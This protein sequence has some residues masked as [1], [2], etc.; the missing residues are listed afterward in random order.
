M[1]D[2][3]LRLSKCKFKLF[4][5]IQ[6]IPTWLMFLITTYIATSQTVLPSFIQEIYMQTRIRFFSFRLFGFMYCLLLSYNR[7]SFGI[8]N[9]LVFCLFR[10]VVTI[11]CLTSNEVF[12]QSVCIYRLKSVYLWKSQPPF[13]NNVGWLTFTTRSNCDHHTL[14]TRVL[15]SVFMQLVRLNRWNISA[16]LFCI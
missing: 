15:Y 9:I 16:I 11:K 8:S 1:R 12:R 2:G 14:E 10:N 4:R 5:L 6:C 7:L 3:V 13:E